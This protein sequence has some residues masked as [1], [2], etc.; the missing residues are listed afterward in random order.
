F[1]CERRF[2]G[3]AHSEVQSKSAEGLPVCLDESLMRP[4]ARQPAGE[5]LGKLRI[6][7]GAEKK[8]RERL[9]GIGSER[10]LG[11]AEVVDAGR[12]IGKSAVV[13]GPGDFITELQS[14]FTRHLGDVVLEDEIVAA[15]V[16]V[17]EL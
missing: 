12:L 9:A 17:G 3:P 13:P 11:P 7:N 2:V 6:R 14:M 15:G 10:K 16:S 8:R 1:R 5:T 4:P